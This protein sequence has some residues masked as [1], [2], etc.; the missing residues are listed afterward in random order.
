MKQ[1]LRLGL[2]LLLL[3]WGLPGHTTAPRALPPR[4]GSNLQGV[5]PPGKN[6]PCF[7]LA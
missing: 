4:Q 7:T 2:V 3:L 1:S 5:C 6:T